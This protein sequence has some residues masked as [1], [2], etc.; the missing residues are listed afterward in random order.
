MFR[1]FHY[2]VR[3]RSHELAGS[4]G[5]DRTGYRSLAGVQ[6]SC[7]SDGAGSAAHSE[8][9]AQTLVDSGSRLLAERFRAYVSSTDG[10]AVKIEIVSHLVQRLRAVA[11]RR[12]VRTRDLAATFLAIA[13]GDGRFLAV[14]VGD[15]VI[16]YVKGGELRMVS[17]P[18]NSEFVNQT[19][20]L[21]SGGAAV[22]M[23]VLRGSLTDVSGFVIMSDGT[24]NSLYDSRARALAPACA[25]I[26]AVLAAAP[27]RQVRRPDHERRLRRLIDTKVRA[28]TRDDCSIG[29]LARRL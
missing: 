10:A 12:E 20:F 24:A 28:A 29:V 15:G 1:E 3:G 17:G 4:R 19:A 22:A 11:R 27:T 23:R 26:I 14:H 9:G 18:D 25:K 16:G 7:L 8:F 6:V 13:A 21:T 5:Q 2:Q